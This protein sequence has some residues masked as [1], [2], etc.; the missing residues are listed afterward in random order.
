V[1]AWV[2]EV[3]TVEGGQQEAG[4]GCEVWRRVEGRVLVSGAAEHQQ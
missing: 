1:G 2:A 4:V 3:W